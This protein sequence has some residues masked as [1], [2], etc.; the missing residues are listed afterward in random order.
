MT[1]P[2]ERVPNRACLH[3]FCG[4]AGAGKT[5]LARSVAASEDG[6]LTS[7]D[8]WLTRLYGDQMQTFEDYR[9]FSLRLRTVVEPLSV[10][11]LRAGRNVVLD[12]PANTKAARSWFRALIDQSGAAHVLHVVD[13]S[14]ATCLERIGQRNLA[15]PE[16]SH[17]LTPEQF[18]YIFTFFETPAAD[19]AF[20]V[21]KYQA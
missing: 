1:N 18:A 12:F 6:F 2:P 13:S 19:E 7:E 11:L 21:M 15:R 16:G 20:E 4:K 9:R 10:E 5:T 14:D 3:F 17:H 8:V